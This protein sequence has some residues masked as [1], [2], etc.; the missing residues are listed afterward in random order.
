MPNFR[1]VQ[2]GGEERVG[3]RLEI[4][5]IEYLVEFR[6]EAGLPVWRYEVDDFVLEKR[7]YLPYRQNTV[8]VNYRLIA[9]NGTMRLKLRP[10][11]NFRGH[12]DADRRP[13]AT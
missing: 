1:T 10:A 11:V 5:G 6:L 7:I 3:G 8:Y 12:D 13:A 9:G 4:H 2:F